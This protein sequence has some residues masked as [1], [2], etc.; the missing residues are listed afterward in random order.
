MEV[1]DACPEDTD[2]KEIFRRFR[3]ELQCRGFEN[4]EDLMHAG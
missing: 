4:V 1:V 2:E 3:H